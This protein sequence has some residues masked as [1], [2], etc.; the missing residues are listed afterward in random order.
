M[1]DYNAQSI[2]QLTFREGVRKRVGIYLGSAD[3]TGAGIP[4][5]R[6]LLALRSTYARGEGID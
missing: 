5:R 3:H 1:A 2:Q 6:G 4:W